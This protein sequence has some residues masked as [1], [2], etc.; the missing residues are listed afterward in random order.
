MV[1]R[2]PSTDQE[3]QRIEKLRNDVEKTL[4]EHARRFIESRIR[5]ST[6]LAAEEELSVDDLPEASV[7]YDTDRIPEPNGYKFTVEVDE[8]VNAKPV[9][10]SGSSVFVDP[11][12]LRQLREI[13]SQN[14]DLS[15]LIRFCEELNDCVTNQD[16]L[17]IAML[18]RAVVD[19]IPPIF[20]HRTFTEVINNYGWTLSNKDQIRHLDENLRKVADSHL[21]TLIRSKES[22]PTYIQ[23]NF[24]S[25]IDVL[26]AEIVR[27]L[28]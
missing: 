22:L 9:S 10:R 15:K 7:K 1:F 20:G 26:L 2:I 13:R 14:F 19:H 12:R 23:V 28:K 27:I 25:D 24:A 3:N 16:F 6:P 8:E 5:S 21:H 17:A 11:T 4:F 18:T